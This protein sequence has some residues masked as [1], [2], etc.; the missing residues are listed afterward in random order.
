M[1]ALHVDVLEPAPLTNGVAQRGA[2]LHREAERAEAGHA[3]DFRQ[4][5]SKRLAGGRFSSAFE[6]VAQ[7][8]ETD[9]AV[10]V[11]LTAWIDPA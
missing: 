1:G 2:V 6:Q 7:G 10:L 9:V 5:E 11:G 8:R 4:A 3:L